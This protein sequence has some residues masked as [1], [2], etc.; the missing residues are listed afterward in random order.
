MSTSVPG[1]I[2][3]TITAAEG[4]RQDP[5]RDH[6]DMRDGRL[7]VLQDRRELLVDGE[8]VQLGGRAFDVLLAL[9]DAQGA[10]VSTD[11]LLAAAWP[12]RIVEE[13]AVQAQISKLR[14][15]LGQHR[16]LVRN[17]PG[18][19]YQL[20]AAKAVVAETHP[21]DQSVR[22]SNLP[23]A[24]SEL[25][26]RETEVEE[27]LELAAKHRLVTLTASGGIGKTSLVTAAARRLLPQF[28]DGVWFVEL[29][30]LGNSDRVPEAVAA[31][32]AID[33]LP[34]GMSAERLGRALR[35][36]Q[37][38]IVLDNCEHVVEGAALI[39]ECL[40]RS[41]PGLRVLATSREPLRAEGEQVYRVPALRCR[42]PTRRMS[43]KACST[44]RS[45]CSSSA[46]GRR[47]SAW[48][49]TA[50]GWRR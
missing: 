50:R 11:A 26:A 42:M 45:G 30:S 1:N 49:R 48:S 19:G 31:A 37:L 32:A 38:L 20:I 44:A 9:A 16:G 6:R 46:S 41:D 7:Q 36:K 27:V 17:V 13:N 8:P 18:R 29:A 12:G 33:I 3:R 2:Q 21:V 43:Q 25:I 28:A 14:A 23:Q 22:R 4:R 47:V 34:G 5:Q 39:A 24:S 15:A 10:V 35:Q 40:L